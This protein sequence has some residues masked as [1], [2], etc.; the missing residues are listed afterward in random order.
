MSCS[1][2]SISN[3]RFLGSWTF[4]P[5]PPPPSR[6]VAA[7]A[8][9]LLVRGSH[10]RRSKRG[11]SGG[12]GCGGGGGARGQATAVGASGAAAED[13][14][15]YDAAA[16]SF[17]EEASRPRAARGRVTYSR[18]VLAVDRSRTGMAR[19]I[20]VRRRRREHGVLVGSWTS[21]SA[22]AA[23]R[24]APGRARLTPLLR[25]SHGCNGTGDHAGEASVAAAGVVVAAPATARRYRGVRRRPWGKWAAEI[26]DP[27]KAARVW[28]GT[29]RTAED[30]ARA[31]DAAELRFRGRRAKLNFPEEASRP[32]RPWKGH[33]VDHMSCSPPSIAN[34]RF[35]G[36]WIFGPPPPSRSV[37]A[38]TTTLLGGSH[39][40][41]GADNG[42]E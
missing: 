2:P 10:A 21:T 15:G 35:L 14:R 18:V 38:A 3:A 27:R 28:L 25:G 29:F 7:A 39:G 31:Y 13:A 12:A 9:T 6:S 23:V 8:T 41:N 16:L 11:I 42:R 32:R 5:P 1:P 33:D 19:K 26:R 34:A 40:S 36:S 20:S 4:G 22:A 17:P 37:A 24:D 30:A